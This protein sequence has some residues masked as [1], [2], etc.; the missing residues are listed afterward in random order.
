MKKQEV[1]WKTVFSLAGAFV[2]FQ[3]GSGFATGQE[4]L[5]YFAS[6]GLWGILGAVLSMGLMVY[7]SVS[8]MTMGKKHRLEKGSDVFR[9]YCGE[10]ASLFFDFFSVVFLYMSYWVMA[11]GAGATMAQH[12]GMPEAAGSVMMAVLSAGTVLFGLSRIVDI[13]GRIGPMIALFAIAIGLLVILRDPSAIGEGNAALPYLSVNRAA[14]SW[15]MAAASYVG[16]SVLGMAVFMSS[17]GASAGSVKEAALGGA[18]G[19]V[20]FCLSIIVVALGLLSQIDQVA[21]LPIPMLYLAGTIHRVLPSCFTLI[22]MAGIYT[23]A[24]PLLWSVT[25][26]FAGDRTPRFRILAVILAAVGTLVSLKVPFTQLVGSVYL[27][28]GYL[29]MLFLAW[30]AASAALRFGAGRRQKITGKIFVE[31]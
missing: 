10:T 4:I 20:A 7:A 6:Y 5:Q 28:N 14:G 30:S 21:R 19:A 26:R 27:I 8:F 18:L 13:L 23:T 12:Y 22:I 24:V 17:M 16:F 15:W 2:A 3:I 1:H 25:N 11:A 29:G 31:K 9:C